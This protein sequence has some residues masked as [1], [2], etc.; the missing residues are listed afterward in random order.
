MKYL[1]VNRMKK[2]VVPIQ[3]MIEEN[4]AVEENSAANINEHNI[5]V[6]QLQKLEENIKEC[7]IEDRKKVIANNKISDEVERKKINTTYMQCLK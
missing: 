4:S 1:C 6:V 7:M 2:V 3:V 5:N